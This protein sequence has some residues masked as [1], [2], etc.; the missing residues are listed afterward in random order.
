[1]K[2]LNQWQLNSSFDSYGYCDFMQ[3]SYSFM[4]HDDITINTIGSIAS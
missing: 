4:S 1:M 3:L 2:K